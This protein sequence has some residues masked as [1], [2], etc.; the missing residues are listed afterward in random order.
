MIEVVLHGQQYRPFLQMSMQGATIVLGFWI[1]NVVYVWYSGG[2]LSDYTGAGVTLVLVAIGF[3]PPLVR[4]RGK[5]SRAVSDEMAS[6]RRRLD[7]L[8]TRAAPAAGAATATTARELEERLDEALVMLRISYL[9][10]LHA[11]LGQSEAM[12]IVIKLLVPITTVA[13]YGYKYYRGMP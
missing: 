4:L 6:L 8:I 3:L 2:D 13:W 12:D 5:V 10:K 11:Q 7:R 1:V 9:E